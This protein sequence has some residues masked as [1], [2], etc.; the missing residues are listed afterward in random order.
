MPQNWGTFTDQQIN[1]LLEDVCDLI[2]HLTNMNVKLRNLDNLRHQ[3]NTESQ[4]R[5]NDR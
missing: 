3:L 4:K 2:D 5:W 1:R